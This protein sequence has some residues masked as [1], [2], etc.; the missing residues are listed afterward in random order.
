MLLL[1]FDMNVSLP[2]NIVLIVYFY[3]LM[4]NIKLRNEP[5]FP[6][7]AAE[8]GRQVIVSEN[9]IIAVGDHD[10]TKFSLVF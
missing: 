9:E 10:F 3:V 8:R 2:L 5:G 6:V 4:T 7:A 1:Y